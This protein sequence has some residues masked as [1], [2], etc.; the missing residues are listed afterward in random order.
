ML[1]SR[2][3][4]INHAVEPL[5]AQYISRQHLDQGTC[6]AGKSST[7]LIQETAPWELVIS[8][9]KNTWE[10]CFQLMGLQMKMEPFHVEDKK[11]HL[12]AK[13]SNSR[14]ISNVTTALSRLNG[15]QRKVSNTDAQISYP[16]AKRFRNAS[17]HAWMVESVLMEYVHVLHTFQELTARPK[18]RII[19]R[20]FQ[21]SRAKVF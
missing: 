7:H 1:I 17:A 14:S 4:H 6:S 10:C 15:K 21:L 16:L 8:P 11:L 5:Q 18:I 12:R 13:N 2:A 3:Y 9:M 19:Q 20:A